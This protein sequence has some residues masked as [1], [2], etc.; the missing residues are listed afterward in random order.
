MGSFSEFA[1]TQ[2]GLNYETCL[3]KTTMVGRRRLGHA[4]CHPGLDLWSTF[5]QYGP[6][7]QG[8]PIVANDYILIETS[9]HKY[10]GSEGLGCL[11]ICTATVLFK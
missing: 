6:F 9:R 4:H 5:D 10:R 11:C 1:T 8:P 3:G 2:D 7:L